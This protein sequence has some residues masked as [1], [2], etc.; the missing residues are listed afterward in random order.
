MAGHYRGRC[1][2][3]DVVN[4]ALNEDGTYRDSVF[5]RVLGEDYI[6]LAFR[7]AAEADPAAKLYYN[8]YNLERV[9]PKS[10][11]ARRIVKML[12]DE[13][14]RVD[15]I[16]RQAHM[17]VGETPSYDEQWDVIDNYAELGVEVAITEL[18]IRLTV[19][20]NNAT[21][22]Q[23]KTDYANVSYH[24]P[25]PTWFPTKRPFFPPSPSPPSKRS[26]RG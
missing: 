12:Q 16:G 14:I 2:H 21:L 19:P 9:G 23:Q 20:S 5:Y 26:L 10:E 6:K 1:H 4:E 22:G 15:G 8:D 18:D 17:T 3:W 11:G 25:Y 7:L 24:E 13:G